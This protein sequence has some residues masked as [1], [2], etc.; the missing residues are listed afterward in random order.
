MKKTTKKPGKWMSEAL[1]TALK[2]V[3]NG[4]VQNEKEAILQWL[5]TENKIP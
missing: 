4:D 3:V 1:D 5:D 2:A